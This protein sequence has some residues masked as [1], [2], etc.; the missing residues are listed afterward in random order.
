MKKKC[1]P[2]TVRAD[3]IHQNVE[4]VFTSLSNQTRERESII[5]ALFPPDEGK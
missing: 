5:Q 4:T 1:T 2:E 3:S